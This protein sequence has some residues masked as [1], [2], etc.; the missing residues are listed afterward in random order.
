MKSNYQ[1]QS[2]E[3][4]EPQ[5]EEIEPLNLLPEQQIYN[6]IIDEFPPS[7]PHYLDFEQYIAVKRVLPKEWS[8]TGLASVPIKHNII[9]NNKLT[10]ESAISHEN[11]VNTESTCSNLIK[12][13][14]SP[15]WYAN[16]IM[17][18]KLPYTVKHKLTPFQILQRRLQ[19][20][21]NFIHQK[22]NNQ[23]NAHC[24]LKL[25]NVNH[26]SAKDV[27]EDYQKQIQINK[28]RLKRIGSYSTLYYNKLEL[29]KVEQIRSKQGLVDNTFKSGLIKLTKK[30]IKC[31]KTRSSIIN[32]HIRRNSYTYEYGFTPVQ[33]NVTKICNVNN[34]CRNERN[35][36][37]L[38][39]NWNNIS[40]SHNS[41]EFD[42]HLS[43]FHS[44]SSVSV[45]NNK[46]NNNMN[47]SNT[48]Q[49]Q[50]D[51]SNKSEFELKGNKRYL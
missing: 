21:K 4:T 44:S 13:S 42:L 29:K 26:K 39:Y 1:V 30:N 20:I 31:N 12:T 5:N 49:T 45:F 51:L 33:L 8:L 47:C 14:A 16:R 9:N 43:G 6:P 27:E 15:F 2:K 22:Q 10:C 50:N 48:S 41:K 28:I 18:P 3:E 35:A 36:K 37:H 11:N 32:N 25:T 19:F 7:N 23:L 38:N 17:L 46:N 34:S 40:V 24:D